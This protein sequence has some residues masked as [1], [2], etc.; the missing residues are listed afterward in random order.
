M[1]VPL[2]ILI[3]AVTAF[4]I[5]YFQTHRKLKANKAELDQL[6]S[7][8]EVFYRLS[9]GNDGE[10][11]TQ[12]LNGTA[13]P[14]GEMDTGPQLRGQGMAGINIP[15]E[16]GTSFNT[17]EMATRRNVTGESLVPWNRHEMSTMRADFATGA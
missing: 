2:G 1:G 12:E 14:T 3:L 10:Q 5:F 7:H 13:Q 6:R 8:P 16:M 17:N 4:L 9:N 11:G 15:G